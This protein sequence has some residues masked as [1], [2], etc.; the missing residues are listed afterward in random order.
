MTKIF[1]SYS[2]QDMSFAAHTVDYLESNGHKVFWDLMDL[3][4][5]T[6]WEDKIRTAINGAELVVVVISV[7]SMNSRSVGD[8][9]QHALELGKRVVFLVKRAFSIRSQFQGVEWVDARDG[10]SRGLKRLVN[11]MKSTPC[12]KVPITPGRAFLREPLP[13]IVWIVF[14]LFWGAALFKLQFALCALRSLSPAHPPLVLLYVLLTVLL[15]LLVPLMSEQ[16]GL[17][18]LKGKYP[19]HQ[20]FALQAGIV[21]SMTIM[22]PPILAIWMAIPSLLAYGSIDLP[23]IG[24]VELPHTVEFASLRIS[25]GFGNYFSSSLIDLPLIVF[26]GLIGSR[27]QFLKSWRRGVSYLKDFYSHPAV[28]DFDSHMPTYGPSEWREITPRRERKFTGVTSSANYIESAAGAEDIEGQIAILC[29]ESDR[30]FAESIGS[31]LHERGFDIVQVSDTRHGAGTTIVIT[32]PY[33]ADDNSLVSQIE[34]AI[35]EGRFFV[36]IILHDE[37]IQGELANIQSIDMRIDYQKGL[38]ELVRTLGA[39]DVTESRS[40]L[41]VEEPARP[42]GRYAILAPYIVLGFNFALHAPPI[43]KFFFLGFTIF[44]ML[45]TTASFLLA[46]VALIPVAAVL[47]IQGGV[48]LNIQDRN[49]SRRRLVQFQAAGLIVIPMS[50]L[51]ISKGLQGTDTYLVF[52][53]AFMSIVADAV[54]LAILLRSDSLTRW[55][56]GNRN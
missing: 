50:A 18:V 45:E 56:P 28:I 32:S 39:D 14:A 21:V 17:Y 55:L 38:L 10:L 41:Q 22:L 34:R 20:I 12:A 43:T 9:I 2:R 52:F 23:Y 36:P 5:G 7:D 44:Y 8:E 46:A 16:A 11:C 30:P 31:D 42:G 54:V 26:L 1:L 27:Q 19:I 4:P 47:L 6:H 51:I 49:F 25:C 15:G 35:H 3:K 29:S 48:L 37:Q 40:P 33:L 13:S 24:S 53:S